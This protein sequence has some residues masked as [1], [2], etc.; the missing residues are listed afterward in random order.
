MFDTLEIRSINLIDSES[1]YKTF[2]FCR[3]KPSKFCFIIQL[4][5][6]EQITDR[7]SFV[8]VSRTTIMNGF[9]GTLRT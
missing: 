3:V 2:L 8:K 6:T 7:V 4:I 5:I 9:S 1:K